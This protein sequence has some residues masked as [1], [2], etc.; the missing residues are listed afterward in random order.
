MTKFMG[1][2]KSLPIVV[3]FLVCGYFVLSTANVLYLASNLIIKIGFFVEFYTERPD[4]TLNI[5]R[6]TRVL[7]HNFIQVHTT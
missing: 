1:K 7:P 4:Y 3:I 5:D 6:R 2:R